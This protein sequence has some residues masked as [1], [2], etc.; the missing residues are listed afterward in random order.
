M[1]QFVGVL[2]GFL[3]SERRLF[4]TQTGLPLTQAWFVELD[5]KGH[6]AKNVLHG[7]GSQYSYENFEK[8]RNSII[9]CQAKS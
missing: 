9:S 3:N 6:I 5:N 1:I 4:E 2:E 8:D 7:S